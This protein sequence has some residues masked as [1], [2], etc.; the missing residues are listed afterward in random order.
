MVA[1]FIGGWNGRKFRALLEEEGL[2]FVGEEAEGETRECHALIVDGAHPTEVNERGVRV[3]EGAWLRL[4]R[5]LPSGT[6]VVSGSLPSGIAPTSLPD[7]LARLPR[8]PVVDMSGDALAAAVTANVAMIAP[9]R[10]EFARLLDQDDASPADAAAFFGSRGV[11]VLLSLGA[12]GAVY[13]AERSWFVRAP[14]VDADNPVG[15]GDALLGAFLWAKAQGKDDG[16]ALRW[17]VAAG[18]DNARRGG[19][20]AA[21]R[22]GMGELF[23]RCEVEAVVT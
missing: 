21:T 18:A 19:G 6:P 23:D 7:L 8:A 16:E 22:A 3:P 14:P 17:G 4:L 20:G 10:G 15:S 9:N 11:P 2:R 1:G 12:D 5:R 13:A